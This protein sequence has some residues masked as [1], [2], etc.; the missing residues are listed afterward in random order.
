[1]ADTSVIDTQRSFTISANFLSFIINVPFS[2]KQFLSKFYSFQKF[3]Y[4]IFRKQLYRTKRNVAQPE[5]QS[6][7]FLSNSILCAR[8]GSMLPAS[9]YFHPLQHYNE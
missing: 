3:C 5:S 7:A 9:D 8:A 4:V 2:I 6:S 1:M